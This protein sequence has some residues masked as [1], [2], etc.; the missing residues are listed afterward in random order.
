[1]DFDALYQKIMS[2]S[3][4]VRFVMILNKNGEKVSGGYRENLKGFLTEEELNMVLYH[5]GQRWE[6]RKHLL[7]KIGNALYS[8]TEYEKIKRMSFPIDEKHM[9]LVSTETSVDHNMI[10]GKI[11]E[12]IKK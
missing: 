11:L 10:I 7:H 2:L 5:A 8:M 9:V 1:M 4:D 3:P 12:L 6:S